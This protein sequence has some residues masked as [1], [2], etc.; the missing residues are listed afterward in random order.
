MLSFIMMKVIV[1]SVMLSHYA[2]CRGAESH[3]AECRG[4]ESHNANV[5]VVHVTWPF[6]C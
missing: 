1:M 3:Y 5:F 2:E 4:A 6:V